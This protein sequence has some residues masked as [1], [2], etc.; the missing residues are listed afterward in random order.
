MEEVRCA[1]CRRLL[2]KIEEGALSGA[3]SAKCPRCGAF[4]TLRPPPSP[5]PER[6]D[7]DGKDLPCG[8]SYPPRS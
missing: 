6:Q 4:N 5:D 8:C 3:L 2:F 7:R 1:A